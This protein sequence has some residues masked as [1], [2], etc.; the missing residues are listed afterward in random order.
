MLFFFFAWTQGTWSDQ[1]ATECVATTTTT[2]TTTVTTTTLE[3]K[4]TL[5][6]NQKNCAFEENDGNAITMPVLAG[7]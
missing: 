6:Y 1:A 5:V 7:G 2:T 4:W 3:P